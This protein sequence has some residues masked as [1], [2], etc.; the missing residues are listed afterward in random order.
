MK[1]I[2]LSFFLLWW[3]LFYRF[4]RFVSTPAILERFASLEN[5][6]LQ[7]E[8]SFQANALSMSIATPDEGMVRIKLQLKQVLG[9]LLY[10]LFSV[11]W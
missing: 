8:S 4:V 5:E 9:I 3:G 2:L 6:I 7:I 10:E 11:M 1:L